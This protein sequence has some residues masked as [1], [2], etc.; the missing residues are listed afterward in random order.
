VGPVKIFNPIE[1]PS[2]LPAACAPVSGAQVM[3]LVATDAP[4]LPQVH[5]VQ[6]EQSV[7][8]NGRTGGGYGISGFTVKDVP[9]TAQKRLDDRGVPPR[10][11]PV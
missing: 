1:R 3:R 2:A 6:A 5:Q 11:R 4:Q 8:V 9:A 7:R 10:G